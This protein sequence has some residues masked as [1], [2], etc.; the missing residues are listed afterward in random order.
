[1]GDPPPA[2]RLRRP[3]HP[4]S[5]RKE[6][7]RGGQHRR[8]RHG[9]GLDAGRGVRRHDAEEPEAAGGQAQGQPE[10][11]QPLDLMARRPRAATHAEGPPPV[12]PRVHRGGN[13][14]GERVGEL[15]GCHLSEE[16][17]AA[18]VD[19]GGCHAD[20]AEDDE[21]S[22]DG[23]AKRGREAHDEPDGRVRS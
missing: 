7:Q 10:D 14:K 2:G 17:E 3:E 4:P 16:D 9:T 6:L 22:R 19:D 13:E 23:T 11:E 12:A 21:L 18:E 5:H 20:G 15:G 1:M 8:R